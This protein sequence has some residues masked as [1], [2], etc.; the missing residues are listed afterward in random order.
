MINKWIYCSNC[1]YFKL[2]NVNYESGFGQCIRYAPQKSDWRSGAEWHTVKGTQCCGEYIS[3]K[4]GKNYI[5]E[6]GFEDYDEHA[7]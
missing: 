1:I 2:P 6:Y 5:E 3:K 4:D 7:G